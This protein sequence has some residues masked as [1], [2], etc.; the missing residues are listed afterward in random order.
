MFGK[1]MDHPSGSPDSQLN[2]GILCPHCAQTLP[3]CL[4]IRFSHPK[5]L[6]DEV[7]QEKEN[8]ETVKIS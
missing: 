7:G 1:E 4:S 2:N 8:V 6:A 5:S 3:F